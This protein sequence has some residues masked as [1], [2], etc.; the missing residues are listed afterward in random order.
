MEREE[1]T[2]KTGIRRE[3]K[4]MKAVEDVKARQTDNGATGQGRDK[5]RKK[6]KKKVKSDCP[7]KR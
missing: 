6:E 1:K 3:K 4:K 2:N 7:T 5:E